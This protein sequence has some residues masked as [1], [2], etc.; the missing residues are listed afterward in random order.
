[1][2]IAIQQTIKHI[3][4][5]A[6]RCINMVTHPQILQKNMQMDTLSMYYEVNISVKAFPVATGLHKPQGTGVL[7]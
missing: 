3:Q 7:S 2:T 1:M 4:N 6:N 5:T